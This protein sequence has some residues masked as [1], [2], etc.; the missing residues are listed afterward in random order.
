MAEYWASGANG[1]LCDGGSNPCGDHFFHPKFHF[2]I[3]LLLLFLLPTTGSKAVCEANYETVSND[4]TL[5]QVNK[6]RRA[7]V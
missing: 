1:V 4:H 7:Y 2:N 6:L 3:V 5:V